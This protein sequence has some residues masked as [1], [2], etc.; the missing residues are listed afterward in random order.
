MQFPMACVRNSDCDS[1][2]LDSSHWLIDME[3][4][5]RYVNLIC[6]TGL[7]SRT[8]DTGLLGRSL[9]TKPVFGDETPGD[10]PKVC[11]VFYSDYEE[12]PRHPAQCTDAIAV[13]SAGGAMYTIG[14]EWW[15]HDHRGI[16]IPG[17]CESWFDGCQTCSPLECMYQPSCA[18]YGRVECRGINVHDSEPATN[19]VSFNKWLHCGILLSAMVAMAMA[20]VVSKHINT[21]KRRRGLDNDRVALPAAENILPSSKKKPKAAGDK[22]G[23]HTV[24]L[25]TNMWLDLPSG[26][27]MGDDFQCVAEYHAW[28]MPSP[29]LAEFDF[30]AR[31]WD[32]GSGSGSDTSETSESDS[33]SREIDFQSAMSIEDASITGMHMVETDWMDQ[34]QSAIATAEIRENQIAIFDPDSQWVTG[35]LE[36]ANDTRNPMPKP[37]AI[38]VDENAA[39]GKIYRC[40]VPGCQYGSPKRRYVGDHLR[41]HRKKG[42]LAKNFKCQFPGCTYAAAQAR[43]IGEHMRRHSN[44]RPHK[45]SVPNCD[46][47]GFAKGHLIRHMATHADTYKRHQ[48][49]LVRIFRQLFL[50]CCGPGLSSA[51]TPAATTRRLSQ[52][53]WLST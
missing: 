46:Y 1:S 26:A 4:S 22:D 37:A 16:C 31:V 34:P 9:E 21:E 53:I 19:I 18:H 33:D 13:D 12:Q 49:R 27:G 29:S 2:Q 10:R 45:C 17:Q 11:L 24:A 7:P 15:P 23:H 30:E 25:D 50:I 52:R 48:V 5:Y 39:D 14:R 43:Y 8:L 44:I 40:P 51:H 28:M 38:I 3:K 36:S 35:G 42:S 20:G 6:R 32:S 47:A 41:T